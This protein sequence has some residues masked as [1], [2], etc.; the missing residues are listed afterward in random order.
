MISLFNS[1]SGP[2]ER[3]LTGHQILNEK[4]RN[5][6]SQTKGHKKLD[7][8]IHV[9]IWKM[10]KGYVTEVKTFFEAGLTAYI[11]KCINDYLPKNFIDVGGKFNLDYLNIDFPNQ[12]QMVALTD[13]GIP[14]RGFN[15]VPQMMYA[16]L[17]PNIQPHRTGLKM[18]LEL[19]G[20]FYHHS[21]YGMKFYN[22]FAKVTQLVRRQVT[23]HVILPFEINATFNVH[24]KDLKIDLPRNLN[25]RFSTAGFKIVS[26][27]A[28]MIKNDEVISSSSLKTYCP[29][30]KDEE[31]IIPKDLVNKTNYKNV[32]QLNET[33]LEYS[34]E[35]HSCNDDRTINSE[36]DEWL[37]VLNTV[38][39]PS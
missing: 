9:E 16:R 33:G 34:Y 28:V 8:H 13:I 24:T 29:A 31:Y 37:R 6:L 21:H 19:E 36:I 23:T 30:C 5:L 4:V 18:Q 3:N 39:N 10:N 12:Y 25:S 11:T 20:K 7:Q 17:R 2:D 26:D 22:P 27:D 15:E 38:R 35:I 14:F 1:L 32:K